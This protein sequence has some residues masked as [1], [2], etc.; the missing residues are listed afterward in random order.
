MKMQLI[1][2]VDR[3]GD[4]YVFDFPENDMDFQ[5]AM[6]ERMGEEY[7][8]WLQTIGAHVFEAAKREEH[9]HFNGSMVADMRFVWKGHVPILE[10][11]IA[12]ARAAEADMENF[13]EQLRQALGQ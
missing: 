6:R 9:I 3:I 12:E 10:K 5:R 4:E 13:M 2:A 11:A 7:D 8:A 1:T